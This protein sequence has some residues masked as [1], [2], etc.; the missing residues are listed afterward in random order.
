MRLRKIAAWLLITVLVS[1]SMLALGLLADIK[2]AGGLGRMTFGLGKTY[3]IDIFQEV[4]L[5]SAK[6]IEIHT[7][8]CDAYV[9]KGPSDKVSASLSGR[10]VTTNEGAVPTLR[11]SQKGDVITISERRSRESQSLITWSFSTNNLRLDITLPESFSG[12]VIGKGSSGNFTV[13]DLSLENVNIAITSGDAK[14]MG[15]NL[16]KGL[17]L[18][19]SSGNMTVLDAKAKS[20]EINSNSG[21]KILE[22]LNL[23]EKLYVHSSSGSTKLKDIFCNQIIIESNSGD[24]SGERIHGQQIHADIRSG[25]VDL[26]DMEGGAQI[27]STSG[28]IHI[29]ALKPL[30]SY[31]LSARSGNITLTLPDDT[32]FT[33]DSQVSSG[34]ISCAFDL[35]NKIKEEK[36]LSGSFG[37]GEVLIKADTSSGNITIKKR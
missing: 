11:V 4:D 37:N 29:T 13:S 9:T 5:D 8:V 2:K 15:L 24:I 14:L 18:S 6:R 33:L 19:C 28:D 17:K 25:K 21:D 35:S 27:T 12:E 1:G 36:H 34:N 16:Q 3:E 31:Q 10:V 20:A 30:E 7:L 23:E 26:K 22:N 32:G